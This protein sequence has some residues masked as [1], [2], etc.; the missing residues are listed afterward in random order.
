VDAVQI[1]LAAAFSLPVLAAALAGVAWGIIGGALPGISASI[2]M[3]LLLPFTYGMDPT[4]ALTLL[5]ST[6]V[7]AEYG[8]SI[9]A[10]L[11]R[12]PGTGAAA[13][14]VMDGYA[15]HQQGRG[16]EA[17]GLSLAAGVVGGLFGMIILVSCTGVLAK[18]ALMFTPAS[19]F[20]LAVLG[21]SIVAAVSEGTVVKGLMAACLG[22]AISTIGSD[23][24]TAIPRFTFDRVELY[25]GV[26]PI[27]V[28][29]GVF[30]ISEIL[31]QASEPQWARS[32]GRM[33]IRLPGL[34]MWRRIG[35]AVGI[36]SV[37]GSLE[38]A[39]PGAGGSVAS[40][41][42]YNEAKRW[43]RHKEEFGRGSPEGIAAPE[44]ANNA[45]AA[46]ALIPT[47]SFGVPGSNST[48]VLLGG[49]LIHGIE[50]G[51]MLFTRHPDLVYGLFGGLFVAN[52]AQLLLG[53]LLLG[54]CLWLVNRPKP[55]L[56]GFIL[57]LV[58]T[59]VY[60]L[61]GSVFD[62]AIVLTGGVLGY[63]LRRLGY[64]ILPLVLGLVLGSLV[65]QNFRRALQL[66]NGDPAIFLEDPVSVVLLSLSALIVASSLAAPLWKRS[67]AT[68]AETGV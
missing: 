24:M 13:A 64:P 38:G 29:I 1:G 58:F 15:M 67:R 32:S 37:V 9:P 45:V 57:V 43:S 66:S 55:Y 49:L 56:M 8:G 62:L 22:L 39:T 23:P 48:A 10:I 35:P 60:T 34:G 31:I 12:T 54:P 2:T 11:I 6:Y 61:D 14:T 20:A 18:L 42:A 28:L 30:A 27:L 7:G 4:V 51:P 3:A 53:F 33:R 40:F 63:V 26:R 36:G 65:E 47:L 21:L 52:L 46:T 5:A 25:G 44:A 41:L 17:L 19:Y 50:P 68:A 16:D 59:G